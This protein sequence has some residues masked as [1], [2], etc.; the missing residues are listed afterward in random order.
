MNEIVKPS[1][2]YHG[3][4]SD[5]SE[6]RNKR[7]TLSNTDYTAPIFLSTDPDFAIEYGKFKGGILYTVKISPSAKLFDFRTLPTG[8]DLLIFNDSG[9]RNDTNKD[10]ELG[11]KVY[12]AFESDDGDERQYSGILSGDFDVM[13]QVDFYEFLK[14]N[15]FDGAYVKETGTLNVYVFDPKLLTII[16]KEPLS[17]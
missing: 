3:S 10:Y 5:F 4:Y 1:V 8:Y 11:N 16:K 12:D 2:F 6:F 9:K 14:L 7:G 13:E 15:K 17:K